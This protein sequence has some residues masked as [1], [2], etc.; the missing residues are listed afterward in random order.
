[1]NVFKLPNVSL[2][3][4]KEYKSDAMIELNFEA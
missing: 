1:M 2:D 3:S 4:C